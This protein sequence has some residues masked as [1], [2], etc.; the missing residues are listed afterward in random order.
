MS[1]IEDTVATKEKALGLR[2]YDTYSTDHK[3]TSGYST[4]N[5]VVLGS[6]PFNDATQIHINGW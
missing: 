5:G 1:H 2:G 4:V 6:D 3:T